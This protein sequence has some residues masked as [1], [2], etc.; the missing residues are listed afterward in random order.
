MARA[1]YIR[2]KQNYFK[3]EAQCAK[4]AISRVRFMTQTQIY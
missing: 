1:I 2:E 3:R 4:T